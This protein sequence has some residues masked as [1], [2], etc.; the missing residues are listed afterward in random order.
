MT[1][2]FLLLL[3]LCGFFSASAQQIT[4]SGRVTDSITALP[5]ESATV[6]LE[7]VQDSAMVD[8]TL[9][10]KNGVFSIKTR[11]LEKPAVLK[12][13]FMGFETRKIASDTFTASRDFGTVALT[14]A[15]NMLGEVVVKSEIP[16][17]RIKNDTLEFNASSFRMRP[18]ANVEALVKQLPGVEIDADG[19]ITVNGKEVK[20]I[21]VNGK[22]FF[23]EN[24]KIALQN[25]PA[26][27]INKV[28]I[29]DLKTKKEELTKQAASSD[30][31][32]INLT[33]DEK[34]NKGFFGK[35]TAGAG[36][37]K[38]YESSLLANY[39]E[40]KRKIS[41]LASSNNINASGFSMNEVFDAMGGGRNSSFYMMDNGAFAINNTYFGSETGITQTHL[42]GG[43]YA[44]EWFK[45]FETTLNYFYVETHTRNNNRTDLTTFL[46][47]GSFN[48]RSRAR[49]ENDRFAHNAGFRAEYKIDSTATL[50][51]E[52]KFSR[53]LTRNQDS[54][55][56]ETR[57]Q[58][59]RLTNEVAT[60]TSQEFVTQ[61]FN[62][63]LNFTKSLPK[64][65]RAISAD[66]DGELRD[67]GR[68]RFYNST[69]NFYDDL[70]GDGT[71]DQERIDLRNQR[72]DHAEETSSLTM[73]VEY[74]EPIVDSV[75]LTIGARRRISETANSRDVFDFNVDTGGFTSVNALLTNR[76]DYIEHRS[77]PFARF[78][79]NR[80]KY[81][82]GLSGGAEFI[83]Y[84]AHALYLGERA[85]V[86]RNFIA[87]EL[88][89]NL[90]YRFSPQ[91]SLY[92][93]Y[94]FRVNMPWLTQLLPI[95]DLSDPLHTITG[96]PD[97]DASQRHSFYGNFRDYDHS[98]KSGYNFYGGGGISDRVTVSLTTY[99]DT[100]ERNTT[101]V[102][103]DGVFNSWWGFSWNK[104]KKIEAHSFKY[105]FGING[106]Y[107][108]NKGFT[109]GL[110]YSA[111]SLRITPQASFTYD[112][113]ELFSVN[114]S[115][116]LTSNSTRYE[117]YVVDKIS[118]L[119]HRANLML[120]SY[121]P[122]HV[123]FG[124]DFTYTYNSNIAGGFRK[125]FFLWN[126]SLGYNF[127]GDKLLA[128]VKVYDVLDQNQNAT[129][130]ITSTSVRDEQN[131]VLKR[132]LMFSLTFKLDKFAGKPEGR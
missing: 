60:G 62:Y 23:D 42:G 49:F 82:F 77:T 108:G 65:G 115:Y 91:K 74:T 40:G 80:K 104:S 131:D 126:I 102:N 98:S 58:D 66:V 36:S 107:D 9:T 34:K 4:L 35:A 12:F 76:Q 68:E 41:V 69:F 116:A 96:N 73:S 47:Q 20:Q 13:S 101:Y 38:R 24:G 79:I 5:L 109:N 117:N 59:E 57:D 125:D 113:G 128:K 32:S 90:N 18:D 72:F 39:F 33:I 54:Y 56:S 110:P 88:S 86:S 127:L 105:S 93:N 85:A 94:S 1:R 112:Y 61:N 78:A 132:Y 11:K 16:P 51:F 129:R 26:E 122:K 8:Y 95:V 67:S 3:C 21:L 119:R 63:E 19:K 97:L 48:T 17:V 114:P 15:P 81:N 118:N 89:T 103:V 121:W 123:V 44:D 87:P 99:A 106:G 6:Y 70:D 37:D 25:L 124:N 71:T 10:D 75:S 29:T 83:D 50:Y 30:E 53:T 7:T 43:N 64:K 92:F 130:S 31:A 14:E 46:P 2:Y 27:L 45:G 120:T 28:Q 100:G 55:S 84:E 111:K 52:P 22:P